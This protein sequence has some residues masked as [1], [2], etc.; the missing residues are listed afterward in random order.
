MTLPG[1]MRFALGVL[2]AGA[3][4]VFPVA[5]GFGGAA[6]ETGAAGQ[7]QA[8]KL[9]T[10]AATG[11][12]GAGMAFHTGETLSYRVAWAAFSSAATV[13]LT[14]PEQRDLFGWKTWHFRATAHTLSPV[15]SL[16][17]VD[18]QFDSYSDEATLASRQYET[19]L[20]EMGRKEDQVLHLVSAGQTS[21]A[22]GP[23]VEVL[24]GT[25]DP[26]GAFYELRSVDWQRT[27]ELLASV[28]DGRD[29]F[30]MRAKR[31]S[32]SE[33]VTVAGDPVSASR[34]TIRV[35]QHGKEMPAIHFSVWFTN[36]A[37]RTPVVIQ[38]Q[39][40]FGSLRAELASA[41]Q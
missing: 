39:L 25:R 27:P 40:P 32:A 30:E 28:Y 21:R 5:R 4:V 34:V 26:L 35:F 1:N 36:D 23:S 38:A 15:R 12:R 14:V 9:N 10:D 16:F 33:T 3:A 6:A 19:H 24:A 2:L 11:S 18:D 29:V 37:A 31:E 20:N 8:A 17:A 22:P 41:P 7:R 13:Q